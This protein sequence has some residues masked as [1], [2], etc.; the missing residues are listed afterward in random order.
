M[1][2]H[3]NQISKL[4]TEDPDIIN[5]SIARRG[6][7]SDLI[8]IDP[9]KVQQ[10]AAQ[11][12]E[13]GTFESGQKIYTMMA[14]GTDFHRRGRKYSVLEEFQVLKKF[15]DLDKNEVLRVLRDESGFDWDGA[16][17]P[18]TWTAIEQLADRLL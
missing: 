9:A 18:E 4:I 12:P 2:D 10:I 1:A 3:I 7:E 5:E 11:N 13:H 8:D 17:E 15:W 6:L 14:Y 16:E